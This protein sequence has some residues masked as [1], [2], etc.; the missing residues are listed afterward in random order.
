MI[1]YPEVHL[2][3]FIN[4][5]NR[6]IAEC[7]LIDSGEKVT[8]HVKNTGRCKELLLPNVE[9]AL[10]YQA[11]PTRKTDYDLIAV[12][13]ATEWI[14]IDSQIP[15]QLASEGLLDKTIILPGL[16]GEISSLKR[17]QTFG[18]SKFDI[19][20]ETDQ[21]EQAFIEVKG[22]TLTNKAIGAFP[23][24]P[25]LRGLKHINELT[26]AKKAGY[27]CYVL[28]IVQLERVKVATIHKKMQP[29]LAEVISLGQKVGLH[30][31]AY[32]CQV[33]P[34]TIKLHKQLPFKLNQAF[35]DPNS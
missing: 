12:K 17:E 26:A 25:T 16:V 24:A 34:A 15:N 35:E 33:S 18:N 8:V 6:F 28:F 14:N 27:H 7:R 19:L 29:A 10:S 9:V 20:V 2:A 32:T 23:D 21:G 3:N 13:K 11:S 1:I 4:R 30:V 5:P 22:M 31:I